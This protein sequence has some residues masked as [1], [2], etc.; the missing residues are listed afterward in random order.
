L[1]IPRTLVTMKRVREPKVTWWVTDLI[2]LAGTH[3]VS[4]AKDLGKKKK[5]NT[6]A[7]ILGGKRR[8]RF[9]S[10]FLFF[11]L[12]GPFLVLL[13]SCRVGGPLVQACLPSV[14]FLSLLPS[15]SVGDL[16]YLIGDDGNGRSLTHLPTYLPTYLTRERQ[17]ARV[18]WRKPKALASGCRHVLGVGGWMSLQIPMPTETSCA[19]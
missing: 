8:T 14:L 2:I 7:T 5:K 15:K 6:C 10:C 13:P 16:E 12:L 18:A 3:V 1:F 4:L 19:Y 9:A 17:N 11:P